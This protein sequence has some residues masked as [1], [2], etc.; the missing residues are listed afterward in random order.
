MPS[1]L[2]DPNYT[3]EK[4]AGFWRFKRFLLAQPM[5]VNSGWQYKPR[6]RCQKSP[7]NHPLQ[8][9]PGKGTLGEIFPKDRHVNSDWHRHLRPG[10]APLAFRRYEAV[11]FSTTAALILVE[12]IFSTILRGEHIVVIYGEC[13]NLI[14]AGP[15]HHRLQSTNDCL[16]V[17]SDAQMR[18]LD[19][20]TSGKT[21][22]ITMSGSIAVILMLAGHCGG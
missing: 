22:S 2:Q 20:L 16:P 5:S 11:L 8:R 4:D 14:I 17:I 12:M 18:F 13:E 19:T 7:T 21:H 9:T 10:S 1:V 6:R 3:P 15:N